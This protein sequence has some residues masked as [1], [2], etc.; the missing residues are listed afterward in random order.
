[1]FGIV[2][3]F[4]CL[5]FPKIYPYLPDTIWLWEVCWQFGMWASH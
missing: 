1:L 2:E 4:S 5:F 3:I